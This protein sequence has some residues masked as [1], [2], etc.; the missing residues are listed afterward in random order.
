PHQH[1]N[2]PTY[3]F[4]HQPYWLHTPTHTTNANDLGMAT[5]AHPL[6]AATVQLA[7][8][9]NRADAGESSGTS[10]VFMG[11]IGLNT[12]PWLAD[13]AVA[14]T[15]LL[16]GT[17]LVDLALHVGDHTGA[18]HLE[19]LTLHTPLTLDDTTSRDLQITT[20]S[21][22][23][24]RQITIHSRPHTDE[25]DATDSEWICHATGTLTTTQ[26]Q[27]ELLTQWPPGDA[28][29]VEISDLY[30]QLAA[31]GY[32]YGST[33]QGVVGIWAQPDGTL[34][35]EIT[36]PEETDAAGHT[37]HPA[38]LDA[39][40]HPLAARAVSS[41]TDSELRLPFA[42]TGVTIHATNATHLRVTL[43]TTGNDIT[44]RA[45]DPTGAPVVTVNTLASRPIDP[46][47]LTTSASNE[48]RNSLFQLAWKPA[49]AAAGEV[50]L[51]LVDV[52]TPDMDED[53]DSND[54]AAAHRAT[55][56]LLTHLQSWLATNETTDRTLVVLTHH[57]IATTPAED[58]RLAHA[59]LWGLIRTAQNEN[60]GRIHLIDTDNP[61][62][63][64]Y[65]AEVLATGEYQLAVRYGQFLVPRLV[66][67]ADHVDGRL[68]IP[69]DDPTWRL[70]KTAP[71]TLDNLA[72]LPNPE[73]PDELAPG[74][75]RIDVRAIGLN[76]RDV[77]IT[78]GMYPGD[79]LLASEGAGIVTE[80]ADDVTNVRVGDRIMGMFPHGV[81]AQTVT[82]HRLITTIPDD[83][84]FTTAAGVPV[85][86]LT[87]Y[88]ALY[89]L[90]DL[91]PG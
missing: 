46:T 57:A 5:S 34:H 69:S 26:E 24:G 51:D 45:W 48:T 27:A 88:Y 29:P 87:A 35:A 31:A 8:S 79:A 23:T 37:I 47:A 15:V 82:D 25:P 3:P 91:Q 80:V 28:T 74:Q 60:P 42:W 75:V 41:A 18:P 14:G 10:T 62:D 4:Q 83:W 64:S 59:P 32:E 53:E 78:L 1:T 66:R 67:S 30:E 61:V 16:P 9:V 70:D 63:T 22:A 43:T 89:D 40:L 54:P 20:V 76:F 73:L 55:E 56:S 2:L 71:G 58:V 17:A 49:E 38:L 81:G 44:V 36:L 52:Y 65:L 86:F 7:D 72:F 85:A 33:F 6:L 84:S 21:E 11:R 50:D 90:A 19:E 68:T 77:L 12:H 13:H 39:A